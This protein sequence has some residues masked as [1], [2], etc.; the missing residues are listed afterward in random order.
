MP[1]ELIADLSARPDVDAVLVE[2]DGSRSRPFKAPG[3][4]EPVVPA[5]T[6]ILV[7]VAGLNSIGQPLDEDHVHRSGVVSELAQ[8]P[9]GSFVTAETVARVLAHPQGGA[10]HCPAGARLVPLLN[11]ADTDADI[12]RGGELAA[13]LLANA[14]VDSVAISCMEREF[15]VLEAWVPT[16]AIILAAGRSTRFGVTKQSLPWEDTTLA[17]RAV[18]IALDSGLDPI[19]V[20][21]GHEAEKVEKALYGLPV[22]VVYNADFAAGQ[23]TSL[24]K[25]LDAL[26][27]RTGAAMFFPADQPLVTAEIAQAIVRAHRR[28]FAPACVPV[29]EGW[30]GNP[31]LFDRTLFSKLRGLRGDEGWRALLE[32]YQGTVVSVT[33]PRA[34][35]MDIDTRK[36]CERLK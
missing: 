22:K 8:V 15:P 36:N 33:A 13:K 18:R 16:A 3:Q 7:P 26:P 2:A 28:T 5:A 35:M 6:A 25:G 23:S 27:W 32:K 10:K 31:V 24:G 30:R 4:H 12:Q 1:S 9:V 29:F 20:V 34:V 21:I 14:N 11:K 19:V 17:A